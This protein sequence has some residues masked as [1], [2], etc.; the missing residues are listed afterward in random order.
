M[1]INDQTFAGMVLA[2]DIKIQL[3]RLADELLRQRGELKI[4]CQALA[5]QACDRAEARRFAV[6]LQ[7]GW[8]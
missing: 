8:Q 5:R 2:L 4:E 6:N 1:N 3:R 7:D